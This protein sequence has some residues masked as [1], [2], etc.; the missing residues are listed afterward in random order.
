[1]IA[2]SHLKH[3]NGHFWEEGIGEV[4]LAGCNLL[5]K[6]IEVKQRLKVY[7]KNALTGYPCVRGRLKEGE[8]TTYCCCSSSLISTRRM[9]QTDRSGVVGC[10][11][12]SELRAH[13]QLA[14]D[15]HDN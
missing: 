10:L 1:M 11:P 2:H 7:L 12:V 5:L 3:T 15:C 4:Q 14:E 8:E 6:T 13:F 9:L